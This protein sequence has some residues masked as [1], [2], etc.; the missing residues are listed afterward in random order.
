[1]HNKNGD[2]FTDLKKNNGGKRS[3]AEENEVFSNVQSAIA[4]YIMNMYRTLPGELLFES[5]GDVAIYSDSTL[6]LDIILQPKEIKLYPNE[7][8][9]F[10]NIIDPW[11]VIGQYKELLR[12]VQL[13]HDEHEEKITIDFRKPE[14]HALREHHP[15]RLNFRIATVDG[16]LIEP[17]DI[18]DKMYMTLQFSY[19]SYY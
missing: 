15:R 4:R 5:T 8:Y 2:L 10:F 1:M 12:I 11:S 17:Y 9:I 18:N 7:L 19:N 3:A 16:V 13:K 6:L 14:F